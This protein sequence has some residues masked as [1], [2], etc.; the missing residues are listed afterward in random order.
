MK[1]VIAC[2]FIIVALLVHAEGEVSARVSGPCSHC[3]TMHN[4]QGGLPMARQLN[5]SRTDFVTD[6][7]PNPT[8]LVKDCIGCHTNTEPGT[9]VEGVPMVFNITGTGQPLAGGNFWSLTDDDANGHNVYGIDPEGSASMFPPPG[10][11]NNTGI[12]QTG[13]TALSCAGTYGCH[14]QRTVVDELDAV[15]GAHHANDTM[16]IDGSSVG[17]S[18]RFLDGILGNE[19]D[20][21]EQDDTINSHNEYKG[22]TSNTQDT[23]SYLCAECHGDYHAETAPGEVGTASPW[24]RHPTDVELRN[25]GEYAGYTTYSMIAPVARTDPDNVSAP[26]QV[27]PGADIVMCLSCHRAHA[28]PYYKIMRWD[29]RGWPGSS[30]TNGCAVCHTWKE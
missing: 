24:F 10:D 18:Y 14:G 17:L 27:T 23:I 7:T 11:R 21:W 9:I 26:S 16:G 19:D 4:S 29:Y 5:A 20:D 8:L 30:D 22:S 15:K 25:D 3:H 28:S 12:T 2:A 6:S 1:N 13:A